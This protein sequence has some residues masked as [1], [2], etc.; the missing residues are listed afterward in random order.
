MKKKVMIIDDSTLM[1]R[2]ISDIINKDEQLTVAD[3]A[4]NGM[5][6]LEK[7]LQG[8]RFDVLLVDI[9]MPRMNG[10]QFLK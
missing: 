6:A 10:V 4:I 2:V 8:E 9:Q 7:L 3:M 1:R 5:L